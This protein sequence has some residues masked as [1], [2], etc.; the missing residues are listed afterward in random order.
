LRTDD[1]RV[2]DD[3]TIGGLRHSIEDCCIGKMAIASITIR[4][5]TGRMA[6]GAQSSIVILTI[7]Q[8]RDAAITNRRHWLDASR[9][10]PEVPLT[11][12][13]RGELRRLRKEVREL[14]LEREIPKKA[15][16]FFAK[17]SD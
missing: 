1:W 8:F 17:Q 7:S 6:I 14:R 11:D 16:A 13:E 5:L 12:D 3:P 2:I 4:R 10:P 9:P 15:T